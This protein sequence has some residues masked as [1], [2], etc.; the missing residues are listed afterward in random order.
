MQ[1]FSAAT[2]Q[3]RNVEVP[4]PRFV[5]IEPVGQCNL[6][7]RMCPVQFRSVG[8]P[9][10]S[11]FMPIDL[12]CQLIDQ[13]GAIDELHLQGLGE[14]L[15]HP[16]FFDMVRY[17]SERGIRVS[18]NTNM[19]VMT[20]RHAA[21]CVASGLHTMHVSLDAANAASYEAIRVRARFDKVLRNLRRLLAARTAAACESPRIGLVA[22]AMR[23]NI[24][25]LPQLV[26]LAHAEG[27]QSLS[28]QH[29][30]HDFGETSLPERYRPM[31]QFIDEQSLL[32]EDRDRTEAVFNEARAEAARLGVALR[33]PQLQPRTHAADV[34][35]RQRCDWP[36]R[37]AYVSYDGKAM[38]CCMV[39]TPDRIHFGDMAKDGVARVWNNEAYGSFRDQLSSSTPPQ[40]C[41]SCAV[42]RGTF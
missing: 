26:R 19:T 17:A 3:E 11:A 40:V 6:R 9:G 33:L 7:C 27:V 24:D 35:G 32:Q 18:T 4:L 23:H 12:Y 41:R 39:A 30:C 13:F 21:Q 42:Y 8:P 38:P 2:L 36:W 22:V 15:L 10:P 29:L 37:G 25:E 5:Q 1:N 34:P 14:P 28:V 31:R 16:R 20:D